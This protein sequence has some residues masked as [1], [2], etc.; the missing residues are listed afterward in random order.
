MQL[1]WRWLVSVALL[2]VVSAAPMCAQGT[3][4]SITGTVTDASGAAVEG[5]SIQLQNIETG[6]TR[7][8]VADSAG[9]YLIPA[10]P[11]GAYEVAATR[12][13]FE[14]TRKTGI[15]LVV[16][17]Q[18]E[19]DMMLVVG[20]YKQAITVED[21]PPIVNLST[22]QVSG[23]VGERQ[24]KELPLNGRSYDGLLSLNPGTVNYSSQRSG[25]VGTSNSAIGNMFSVSGRRPQESLFLLNGI[26]Y[27][28]ASTINLTPGGASGQLLGVEAVREFNVLTDVYGAEYGKRPGAQVNIVTTSG[29]NQIHGSA[30]EFLR[31][32]DLDARNFY[33][34]GGVPGFK[35]NVFGGALGGPIAHDKTFLFGNYEGY[36]QSLGL[37]D[38]TLV[39]DTNARVGLLPNAAGKLVHVGVNPSVL[40]LFSLWPVANG[41]EVGGGIAKSYS[42]PV[43]HVREDFG[44]ARLDHVFSATDTL[45]SVY[46]VDDSADITPSANPLNGIGETLREQV[47]SLSETHVFSQRATNTARVGFSR[48]KF[49]FNSYLIGQNGQ[50]DTTKGWITGAPIGAVVIGGG[51][52]SNSATQITQAGANVASNTQA[53]RNLFTYDDQL[54]INVGRHHVQAGGWLQRIQA[55]DSFA[56]A[57]YGQ[58]SF[59]SLTSFLQGTVSTFTAVPNATPLGW[60]S[61]EGAW[62]AQDT[63]RVRPG[64]EVKLGLRAESTSGWN[65]V[66]GRGSNYLFGPGG[67]IET[68]PRLAGSV[69]TDNRAKF[70]PEP[71]VSLAW[72][73]FGHG[74]TVIR[75][76]FGTFHALLDNLSYRLDQNAPYNTTISLKSVPVSNLQLT[77]GQALPSGGLISP[78]GVQPDAY[79]PNILSWT[80]KIEQKLTNNT[81][82]GL[83]YV[84]SHG[85]HEILSVD[86]NEPTGTI[87]PAAPCPSSLATGTLYYPRNAALANPQLANTTS[88][89][90]EGISSYNALQVDVNHRL[91]TGLQIRGV[92]TFSKSLDDGGTLNTSVGTNTPAFT[93]YPGN[94]KLDWGRSP[95]DVTHLGVIN[96][97]YELPFGPGHAW[98]SQVH[99]WQSK[100]ISGW[101]LGGVVTLQSGFPF[102]PQLGFNPT[103]NGDT[104]NPIRPSWNPA[105]SG[106]VIRG[107]PIQYFDPN[108]FIVPANGTYG[109]VGRDVLIGP[110]LA[111]VDASLLKNTTISERF[112]LQF[113]AE[114]FNILNHTNFSTPNAVVFTSASSGPVSTAG[115]INATAT[116]SRQIQFGLKLL[117]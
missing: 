26:E 27:T 108:A 2:T 31:N 104:R 28:S 8:V 33:D 46:T 90:T 9:R 116:T 59:G 56:Q 35:R 65:E 53:A 75:A 83:G 85:Y 61:W 106:S 30:Y 91:S 99:G 92:Y 18:A 57:Q 45:S 81:A 6:Q 86:A 17:Q 110:G 115:L 84:G 7:S 23:L 70:L 42:N 103:N 79:T 98:A 16:G 113:R 39:P 68:Q 71:R 82:L 101:Q 76:G 54:D 32:S 69:F 36:R 72:D 97:T 13:G 48:G 60:R 22:E 67:V 14:T 58:A 66:H 34:Q 12:S 47:V 11:V 88:W 117:F 50:P 89:F 78:G 64:L 109:N 93:M 38:V 43:Q 100:L 44:T 107:G 102:T 51:T 87:C 74:S 62:F 37:S 112:T 19:V 52:A 80:V 4:G 41:P 25:G 5:A 96:G 24:V 55:N 15:H 49:L 10:L 1:F 40:P 21:R 111:T 63:I 3:A 114:A 95:F 73:P 105:F 94:P 77:P 20:E 29:T